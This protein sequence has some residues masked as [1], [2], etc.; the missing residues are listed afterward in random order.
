MDDFLN[1]LP[2]NNKNFLDTLEPAQQKPAPST[3][4]NIKND[5]KT[6]IIDP[7]LNGAQQAWDESLRAE[8]QR[9]QHIQETYDSLGD[10]GMSEGEKAQYTI[11]NNPYTADDQAYEKSAGK[12]LWKGTVQPVIMGAS[13]VPGPQQAVLA[14][15]AG[16]D[17]LGDVAEKAHSDG[18]GAAVRDNTY[19]PIV[20]WASQDDLGKNIIE[21][22]VSTIGQGALSAL[23]AAIGGRL[24]YH[25]V[26]AGVGRV[27]EYDS[28]LNALDESIPKAPQ[29]TGDS[30]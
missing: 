18:I 23:P 5:I 22:P 29:A 9:V 6:N 12:Q 3:W 10:N 27:G 26:K 25:G 1:S 21:R 20:D 2:D 7:Y 14:P 4:E 8:N 13:M 15:A 19:G 28:G 30:F 17:W 24:V 16:A 11:Q